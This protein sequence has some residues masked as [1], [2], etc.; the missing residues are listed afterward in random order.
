VKKGDAAE[1]I[2]AASNDYDLVVMSTH[3]RTG[4]AGIA[5]G[6]VTS[7][8]V[9]RASCGVLTTRMSHAARSADRQA[10]RR[11]RE[12]EATVYALMA[13]VDDV[14]KIYDSLLQAGVPSKEI[15]LILDQ[16]EF[17]E[18]LTTGERTMAKDGLLTGGLIGGT[19]GGYLALV[20][21]LS[22]GSALMLLG[23]AMALTFTSGLLGGLAGIGMSNDEAERVYTKI[24]DRGALIGVHLSDRDKLEKAEEILFQ[25]GGERVELER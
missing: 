17:Q 8:V 2:I 1:A 18:R 5:L 6:S 22:G 7:K 12:E 24:M 4:V 3:G 14:P 15:S 19:V 25:A 20:G 16:D 11:A 9:R 10:K 23:P 13:N 21:I